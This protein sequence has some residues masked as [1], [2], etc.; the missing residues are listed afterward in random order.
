[1]LQVEVMEKR[2]E[3][4]GPDHPAT[5]TSMDNLASTYSELGQLKEAEELQLREGRSWKG[6]E[7]GRAVGR[8]ILDRMAW[9][10]GRGMTRGGRR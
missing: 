4:L 5:L 9:D 10:H 2:K 1:M 3:V 8:G 7:R 6:L